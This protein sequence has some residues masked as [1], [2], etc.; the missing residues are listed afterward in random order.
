M[1]SL[2]RLREDLPPIR[3]RVVVP[4]RTMLVRFSSVL[5]G[6]SG[7]LAQLVTRLRCAIEPGTGG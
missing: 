1:S 3:L 5:L 4:L 7:R 2:R 6:A